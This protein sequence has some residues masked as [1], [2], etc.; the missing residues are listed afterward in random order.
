MSTLS[1]TTFTDKYCNFLRT[2]L[3][4]DPELKSVEKHQLPAQDTNQIQ[5]IKA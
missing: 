2:A 3:Q 4:E 1:C 5:I